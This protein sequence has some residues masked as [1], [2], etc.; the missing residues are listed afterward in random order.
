MEG[1]IITFVI[2]F[3][4]G[5]VFLGLGIYASKK[6]KPMHFYSGI[7]VKASEI[8]DVK[9]YNK[10]NGIMWIMY[11]LWYYCAAIVGFFNSVLALILMI[12]SCTIGLWILVVH[13]KRIEKKY[14]VK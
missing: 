2:L 6:E 9:A 5:S 13:Y 10:E 7:E 14:R 11:S 4:V 1:N 12:S 3:G 8:R